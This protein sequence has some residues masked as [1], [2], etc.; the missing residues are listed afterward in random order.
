MREGFI[1]FSHISPQLQ[2]INEKKRYFLT[3]AIEN[4]N[5]QNQLIKK[6]R[7]E[8]GYDALI[9]V[10]IKNQHILT[11]PIEVEKI[12]S[13][14]EDMTNIIR[15]AENWPNELRAEKINDLQH[16]FK[17]ENEWFADQNFKVF[18]WRL[19]SLFSSEMPF[20]FSLEQYKQLYG[21]FDF[22]KETGMYSKIDKITHLIFGCFLK[23]CE[24]GGLIN[25]E[26]QDNW[27]NDDEKMK[28]F[29]CFSS[30]AYQSLPF[31]RLEMVKAGSSSVQVLQDFLFRISEDYFKAQESNENINQ[32]MEKRWYDCLHVGTVLDQEDTINK[33]VIGPIVQEFFSKKIESDQLTADEQKF[34]NRL[35]YEKKGEETKVGLVMD[36]SI[37][38]QNK[39]ESNPLAEVFP[40]VQNNGQNESDSESAPSISIIE[41]I[42]LLES[43]KI[44]PVFICLAEGLKPEYSKDSIIS[45]V[46]QIKRG[47]LPTK[48]EPHIDIL[49]A[50]FQANIYDFLTKNLNEDNIK[51]PLFE[52]LLLNEDPIQFRKWAVKQY[53]ITRTQVST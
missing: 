52:I 18:S 50:Y 3:E 42:E 12:V 9:K 6:N 14:E 1:Q 22:V 40:N 38:E 30:T 11:M 32:K 35:G 20:S 53:L 43:E 8:E 44:E 33:E 21:A 49:F 45:L 5:E 51:R 36:I 27:F 25:E 24:I 37:P 23:E 7:R 48:L 34:L 29:I 39:S 17:C 15:Q 41:A 13:L 19:E 26:E 28:S 16:I 47:E 31:E 2:K 10:F 4:I 46:E